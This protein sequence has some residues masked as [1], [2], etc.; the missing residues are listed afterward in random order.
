MKNFFSKRNRP[1]IYEIINLFF[2]SHDSKTVE[3]IGEAKLHSIKTKC[4]STRFVYAGINEY[5][6]HEL[7]CQECGHIKMVL[8]KKADEI[9]YSWTL[10]LL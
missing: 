2:Q 6:F 8:A 9:N 1:K 3:C 7:L 4:E 10:A 5:G